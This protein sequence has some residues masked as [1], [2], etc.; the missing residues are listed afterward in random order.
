MDP[1]MMLDRILGEINRSLDTL[2][3]TKELRDKQAH[4][5]IVLNLSKSI[6]V[7]IEAFQ[8]IPPDFDDEDFFMEEPPQPPKKKNRNRERKQRSAQEG[9]LPF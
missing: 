2:S 3:Q 8:A 6:G 5:E 9:D 4:S 7:F 1:T